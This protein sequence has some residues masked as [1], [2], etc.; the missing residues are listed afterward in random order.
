MLKSF[1]HG[2]TILPKI[3]QRICSSLQ[4]FPLKF[5]CFVSAHD[6]SSTEWVLMQ[7]FRNRGNCVFLTDNC[8][9][10]LIGLIKPKFWREWN[11]CIDLYIRGILFSDLLYGIPK[12]IWK[13]WSALFGFFLLELKNLVFIPWCVMNIFIE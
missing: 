10:R 6:W 2:H 13:N 7:S 5:E 12:W 3:V 8:V 9:G 1:W 4:I 11:M